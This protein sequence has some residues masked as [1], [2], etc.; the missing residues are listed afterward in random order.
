MDNERQTHA[1]LAK[2]KATPDVSPADFF[3]LLSD[4]LGRRVLAKEHIY[5]DTCFWVLLRDAKM[6]RPRKPEHTE[7]LGH[8]RARVHAG[9]TAC[10]VSDAAYVEVMQ[11]DT[12][13][14]SRPYGR[15]QRRRRT[16]F[17]GEPNEDGTHPLPSG[18]DA[19]IDQRGASCRSILTRARAHDPQEAVVE[20]IGHMWPLRFVTWNVTSGMCSGTFEAHRN[21]RLGRPGV[22]VQSNHLESRLGA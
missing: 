16:L 19:S 18:P 3:R 13:L 14:D 7:I 9:S 2:H 17:G 8:L 22:S 6:G 5:L 12:A 15:T 20:T 21:E 11:Q 4:E 10:P 1:N